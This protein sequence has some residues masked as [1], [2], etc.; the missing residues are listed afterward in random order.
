VTFNASLKKVRL[1]LLYEC[2]NSETLK[3]QKDE[4]VG[5][6]TGLA[7]RR[8]EGKNERMKE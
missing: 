2:R 8:K 5:G 1:R 6:P 3:I 7:D 4:E